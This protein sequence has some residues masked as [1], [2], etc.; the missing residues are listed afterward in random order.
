M[1]RSKEFEP[2]VARE[3]AMELF[4][5]QGYHATSLDDLVSE[6][7]VQRYGIY[8]TFKSKQGLF[9]AALEHYLTSVVGALLHD[10]EQPDAGLAA[11]QAYFARMASIART[12]AGLRGCLMCN[13]A[14][15]LAPHDQAVGVQVSAF[16]RRLEAAFGGAIANAQ[17]RGELAPVVTPVDGARYLTGV[18]LGLNVYVKTPV[19]RDAI[20]TYIRVALSAID[21]HPS[22]P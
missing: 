1:P 11:I 12:P 5:R 16:L 13:T 18:V 17:R 14:V 15:E 10:L 7:G 3:R 19:E 22:A 20:D 4:W 21:A 8:S 9:L 6:L 2:A